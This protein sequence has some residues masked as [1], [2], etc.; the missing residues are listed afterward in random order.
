MLRGGAAGGR[1]GPGTLADSAEA[2]GKVWDHALVRELLAQVRVL[3]DNG[4]GPAGE[5][6]EELARM[7]TRL[8][9]LALYRLIELGDSMTH[10]IAIGESLTANLER[11][12][13]PDH[14]DTLNARNSLAAC[15]RLLGPDHSRTQ[16]T[17]HSLAT[18]CQEAERAAEA[19]HRLA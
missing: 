17:R 8:R 18:A 3:L 6:D 10:A 13:G 15:E 9:F 11:L 1:L 2:L 7:L 12:L 14:P 5:A 16:A 19:G 4:R